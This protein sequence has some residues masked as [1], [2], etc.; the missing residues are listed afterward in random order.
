MTELIIIAV[1]VAAVVYLGGRA[2]WRTWKG[3]A[4]GGGCAGCHGCRRPH[5]PVVDALAVD[6]QGVRDGEAWSPR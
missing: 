5:R 4:P 3:T 1:I 6:V 2:L